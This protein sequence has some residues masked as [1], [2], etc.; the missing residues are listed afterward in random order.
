L[1]I[2]ILYTPLDDTLLYLSAAAELSLGHSYAL[3]R[4]PTAYYPVGWSALLAIFFKLFGPTLIVAQLVNLALAGATFF[5]V[6]A[7]AR[8]AFQSQV[9]SRRSVLVLAA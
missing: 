5:L 7:I 1:M 3:D 4:G 8:A 2:L 9:V 6:L